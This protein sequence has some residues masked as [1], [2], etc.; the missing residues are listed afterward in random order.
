MEFSF[1]FIKKAS[2]VIMI[3]EQGNSTNNQKRVFQ[4]TNATRHSIEK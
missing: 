4:I 3:T 1:S 2:N